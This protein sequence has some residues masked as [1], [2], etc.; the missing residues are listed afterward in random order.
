M[1]SGVRSA[2]EPRRQQRQ[3]NKFEPLEFGLEFNPDS[4]FL[5]PNYGAFVQ[6]LNSMTLDFDAGEAAQLAHAT[7]FYFSPP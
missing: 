1:R 6:Q 3:R 7:S 4:L 2:P 5:D